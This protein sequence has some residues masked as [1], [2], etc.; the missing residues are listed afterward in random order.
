MIAVWQGLAFTSEF[1]STSIGVTYANF[2]DAKTR[3]KKG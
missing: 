2:D 3:R 1:M